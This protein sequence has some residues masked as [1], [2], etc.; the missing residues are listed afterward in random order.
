MYEKGKTTH[1]DLRW[2]VNT[3]VVAALDD[4]F[5]ICFKVCGVTFV[6]LTSVVYS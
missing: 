6:L 5:Y 3:S 2:E 4:A 1:K